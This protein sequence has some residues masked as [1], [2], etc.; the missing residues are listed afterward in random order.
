[1]G[2]SLCFVFFC[3]VCLNAEEYSIQLELMIGVVWFVLSDGI[4]LPERL[5]LT[6]F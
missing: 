2:D 5:F 1:V 4:V 3:S 6:S